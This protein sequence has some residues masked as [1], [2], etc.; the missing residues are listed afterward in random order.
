[1]SLEFLSQARERRR[2]KKWRPPLKSDPMDWLLEDDDPSVK[3]LTLADVLGRAKD[4]IME[5][6]PAPKIR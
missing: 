5:A 3:Y 1:M 2:M 4:Q 6:G